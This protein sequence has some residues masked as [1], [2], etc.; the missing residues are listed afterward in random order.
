MEDT[1][2]IPAMNAVMALLWIPERV[3]SRMERT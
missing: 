2:V 1:A 3:A